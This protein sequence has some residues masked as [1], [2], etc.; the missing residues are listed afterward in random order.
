MKTIKVNAFHMLSGVTSF[1]MRKV[2]VSS[3]NM[4]TLTHIIQVYGACSGNLH[5]SLQVVQ[6]RAAK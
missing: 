5:S 4:V 3:L 2:V 1:K 6:K